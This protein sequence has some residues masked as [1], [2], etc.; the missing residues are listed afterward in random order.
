M[1]AAPNNP[2]PPTTLIGIERLPRR[3]DTQP[4]IGINLNANIVKNTNTSYMAN[5]DQRDKT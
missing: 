1:V 4:I 3:L 2:L 5:R